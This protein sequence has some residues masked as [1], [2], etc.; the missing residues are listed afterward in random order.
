[1]CPTCGDADLERAPLAPAGDVETWTLTT[2]ATPEFTDDAPYVTAVASFGPVRL[3]GVL[4]GIDADDVER[5]L[6]VEAGIED[7]ETTAD[8]LVVFRPR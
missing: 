7:R 3:T 2:V 8:P 4:R 1:V 6:T 5:G